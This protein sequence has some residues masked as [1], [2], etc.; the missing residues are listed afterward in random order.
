MISKKE[1]HLETSLKWNKEHPE[2]FKQ[3]KAEYKARNKEKHKIWNRIWYLR[4]KEYVKK[5]LKKYHSKP[6]V[7]QHYREYMLKWHLARREKKVG[8]SRPSA[9][10]VCKKEGIRI[11]VDHDHKTGEIRG[12]L[13]DNCNVALGRVDDSMVILK[14]LIKYLK[15]HE[16]IVRK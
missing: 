3:I 16:D 14:E 8:S 11:C 6:E 4:N 2:R 12:W 13:C 1:K 15:K 5:Y 9:C 10:P 7:K